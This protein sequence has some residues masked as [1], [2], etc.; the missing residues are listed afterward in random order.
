MGRGRIAAMTSNMP[1]WLPGVAIV[2]ALFVV[3]TSIAVYRYVRRR[4]RWTT[5]ADLVTDGVAVLHFKRTAASWLGVYS[6]LVCV[7]PL[8]LTP[9]PVAVAG[10]AAALSLAVLAYLR[11]TRAVQ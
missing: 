5:V 3:G 1:V 10:T 11:P 9:R 7:L 2:V 4:P 6:C 8:A